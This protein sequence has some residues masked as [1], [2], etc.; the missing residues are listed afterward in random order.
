MLRAVFWDNDGVL[1]DTEELYFDATRSVLAEAG[2]ALSTEEYIDLGLRQGRSV[3]DLVRAAHGDAEV[4]RLRGVRNARYAERLAAGVVALDGIE[5]VLTALHGRVV[6]GVV[7]SSNPDHFEIAHRT[8]GLRRYFDFVL[9]NGDY[10][11]TKPHP[12]GYLAA[13]ARCGFAPEQCM[14][15]EDSERGLAAARA[16]GLRCIVVPRGLTRGCPFEGAYRVLDDAREI[17]PTLTPLMA[18]GA[19]LGS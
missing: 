9:T 6:M 5:A 19:Q 7:T 3:F 2:F 1:V 12:S 8:T 16:A 18:E 10:E 11:R 15:I 13:L 14:V 17:V 4:E